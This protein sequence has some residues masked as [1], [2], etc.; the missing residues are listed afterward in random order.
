MSIYI[1]P[2]GI[3]DWLASLPKNSRLS[4][5]DFALSLGVCMQTF[6]S[7]IRCSSPL[8][9]PDFMSSIKYDGYDGPSLQKRYWKAVTVRNY[10]RKL[11]RESKS[12]KNNV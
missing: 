1:K 11:I 3:P 8:P 5:K 9:D 10:I 7:R 2:V 6:N 4:S 12:E